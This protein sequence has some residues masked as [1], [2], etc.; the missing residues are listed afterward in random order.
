MPNGGYVS[1]ANLPI[2]FNNTDY[3]V[4]ATGYAESTDTYYLNGEVYSPSLI[5]DVM[6]TVSSFLLRSYR[7]N[8]DPACYYI[9]FGW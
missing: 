5:W 9:A 3:L 2:N 7:Q 1:L 8:G 4:L 6:K